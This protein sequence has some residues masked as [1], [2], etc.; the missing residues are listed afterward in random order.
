[1]APDWML[2]SVELPLA[3]TTRRLDRPWGYSWYST[4]ASREPVVGTN[5]SSAAPRAGAGKRDICIRGE[6]PSGGGVI[7]GLSGWL[8]S[9]SPAG[10]FW[11]PRRR[12]APA[13]A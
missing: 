8:P 1:M 6:S 9:G 5:G 2:F 12:W 7:L 11:A 3:S 4:D 13:R 10:G